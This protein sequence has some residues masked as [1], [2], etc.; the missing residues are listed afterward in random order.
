MMERRISD[1]VK[2]IREIMAENKLPAMVSFSG[3]KD[4][5]ATPAADQG[6]RPRPAG[7]LHR[8]RP[9][10]PRDRRV[11][12]RDRRTLRTGTDRRAR[13][14][15]RVLRQPR[16]SSAARDATIAGA[17]RP[18]SSADGQGDH[19]AFPER[20]AVVHRA[21][22][23]RVGAEG[24]Q[25]PHLA[26]P[27]DPGTDRGLADPALDRAARLDLHL[28]EQGPYNPWYEQGWTAS[29]ASSARP[30]TW[31]SWNWSR[32]SRTVPRSGTL[33][34]REYAERA[35][36]PRNGWTRALAMETMPPSIKE[37]LAR[38]GITSRIRQTEGNA[39]ETGSRTA[40]AADAGGFLA[41]RRSGSASRGRS[42]EA[43]PGAVA[44]VLNMVGTVDHQRG[45]RVVLR[46][47]R[48][49]VRGGRAHRQRAR[50]RKR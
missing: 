29:A 19:G 39:E 20:R 24:G 48:H 16:V 7:L 44:N 38:N 8:H 5:L 15:E 43:G 13:P 2:F 9:G 14:G 41:L 18:T 42:P 22:A 3:G 30:R 12:Q 35:A 46:R 32:R 10:V 37:E 21:E 50:T 11:R 26:E 1:A 4:S 6:C 36:C 33:I 27:M 31:Q 47:W 34:F 17:A 49:G 25:A 45:R 40:E 28:H 23:I